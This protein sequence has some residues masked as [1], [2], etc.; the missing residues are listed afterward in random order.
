MTGRKILEMSLLDFFVRSKWGRPRYVYPT[1]FIVGV[2]LVALGTHS[3]PL[4]TTDVY[5]FIFSVASDKFVKEVGVSLVIAALVGSTVEI[6]NLRRHELEREETLSNLTTN[7]EKVIA[8][9]VDRS[10]RE[11]VLALFPSLSPLIIGATHK[12]ILDAKVARGKYH[13]LVQFESDKGEGFLF[14][15]TEIRYELRNLSNATQQCDYRFTFEPELRGALEKE[16][17]LNYLKIASEEFRGISQMESHGLIVRNGS[18]VKEI[19]KKVEVLEKNTIEISLEFTERREFSDTDYWVMTTPTDGL[20]LTV[21][22]CAGLEYFVDALHPR[23][24]HPEQ[25]AARTNT[26]TWEIREGLLPG[27]G[28]LLRWRLN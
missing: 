20:S 21:V 16:T 6:Y 17:S 24:A 26:K 18:Q 3:F 19:Y 23:D 25:A 10:A 7:A 4:L 22:S 5:A 9:L 13:I 1:I 28:I 12:Q 14:V 27:Q 11:G 2:F 15:T 8:G